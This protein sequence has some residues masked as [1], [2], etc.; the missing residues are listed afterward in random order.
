MTPQQELLAQIKAIKKYINM[1]V[2]DRRSETHSLFLTLLADTSCLL[3]G[4]RGTSKTGQI[5]LFTKLAGLSLFETLVTSST[6]PDQIFGPTDVPAL[7][8]GVQRMTNTMLS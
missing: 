1:N 3:L 8:Q 2:V 5:R 4:P 6:K 7:A